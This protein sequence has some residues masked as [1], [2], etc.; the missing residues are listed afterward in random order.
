MK[1]KVTGPH[2]QAGQPV[3][4]GTVIEVPE[5]IGRFM[6]GAWGTAEPVAPKK[7]APRKRA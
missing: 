1:V 5:R 7:K 3:P 2:T 6:C 4:V